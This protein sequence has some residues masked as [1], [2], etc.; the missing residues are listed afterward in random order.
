MDDPRHRAKRDE[1]ADDAESGVG[2]RAKNR[3]AQR[4]AVSHQ[5]KMVAHRHVMIKPDGGDRNDRED[6]GRDAR[7]DHPGREWSVD[8][9]LHPSP[10]REEGEGPEADRSQ[11]ITVN[12]TSDHFRDHVIGRAEP[13]RAEPEEEQIIR[14]PPIHRGLHHALHRN[15]EKHDLR[16]GVEPREP[17]ERA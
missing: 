4:R 7:G 9:S 15:N 13:D 14:K 5:R 16:R 8:Q 17:E 3:E 2:N 10:T 1:H 6:R 12:R 11:V